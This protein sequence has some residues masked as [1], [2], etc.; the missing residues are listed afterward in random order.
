MVGHAVEKASLQNKKKKSSSEG[1]TLGNKTYLQ[2]TV[3]FL[4]YLCAVTSKKKNT[5]PIIN[6]LWYVRFVTRAAISICVSILITVSGEE[7][8]IRNML[9]MHN[10]FHTRNCMWNGKFH[11]QVKII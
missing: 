10:Q 4:K 6:T 3:N 5:A 2:K 7:K 11:F 9:Q 8:I 1:N